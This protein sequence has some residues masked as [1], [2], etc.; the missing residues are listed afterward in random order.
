MEDKI[1]GLGICTSCKYLKNRLEFQDKF[2]E[3][4]DNLYTNA[5]CLKTKKSIYISRKTIEDCKKYKEVKLSILKVIHYLLLYFVHNNLFQL[6]KY[7]R[8]V[9]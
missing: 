6:K 7:L 5:Q 2:V 1:S 8:D 9:L 3:I 4:G